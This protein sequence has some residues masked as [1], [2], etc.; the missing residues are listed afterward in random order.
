MPILYQGGHIARITIDRPEARDALDLHHFRDLA[1]A[2]ESELAGKNFAS[3]DAK[4]GPKAFAEK[5][6]PVWKGR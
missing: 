2:I 4:E 1:N 3:Q 5:R 6:D